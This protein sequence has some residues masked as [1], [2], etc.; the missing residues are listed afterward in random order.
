MKRES[1]V[2]LS[3][4]EVA[5]FHVVEAELSCLAEKRAVAK[6]GERAA[7][8]LWAEQERRARE[9]ERKANQAWWAEYHRS[10]AERRRRTL[11]PLASYHEARVARLETDVS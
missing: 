10:Q 5:H 7:E 2:T 9:Q 11:E 1:S 3:D 6:L 8:D 4:R